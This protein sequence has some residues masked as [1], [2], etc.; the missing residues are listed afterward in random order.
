L[1]KSL[2]FVYA[3]RHGENEE[4]RYSIRSV[5]KNFPDSEVF[6][7]GDPPGWYCGNKIFVAQD[8][9]RYGN[10]NKNINEIISSPDIPDSFIMMNDDFYILEPIEEIGFYDEGLLIE[11]F[12]TYF[13]VYHRSSY[14]A[15]IDQTYEYLKSAGIEQPKSYELHVPMP[16]EKLKL[17]KSVKNKDLLWRSVYGNLFNVDSV[18]IP[19]VKFY[20][21]QRMAFKTYNYRKPTLP[22]LS[23]EDESFPVLHK[24]LLSIVFSEKSKYEL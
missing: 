16:V 13:D 9:G 5:A 20:K 7:V 2:T 21:S 22:F 17:A 10:L 14:V 6:V 4:L 19:D 18:T 11:K 23:S 15:K 1:K 3:C 8:S 12:N 24:N